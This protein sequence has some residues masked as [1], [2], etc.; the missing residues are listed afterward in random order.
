MEKG[1]KLVYCSTF[2]SPKFSFCAAHE[3]LWLA[4][5]RSHGEPWRDAPNVELMQPEAI[6]GGLEWDRQPQED[7]GRGGGHAP[8]GRA[9]QP[10]NLTPC[11]QGQ[12]GCFCRDGGRCVNLDSTA[13]GTGTPSLAHPPAHQACF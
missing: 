4:L 12:P 9:V 5:L 2:S 10:P 7:I 3:L 11:M 1:K 6:S 8:G 13:L